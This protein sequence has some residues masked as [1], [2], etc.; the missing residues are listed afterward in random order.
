MLENDRFLLC[1]EMFIV[2]ES[3]SFQN[4]YGI[5]FCLIGRQL[6]SAYKI[7]VIYLLIAGM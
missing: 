1:L 2:N 7:E 6:G 3:I 5:P 4:V